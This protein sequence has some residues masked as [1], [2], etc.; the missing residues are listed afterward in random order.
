MGF[1]HS[2]AAGTNLVCNFIGCVSETDPLF[3]ST[4]THS[5]KVRQ[6][7]AVT[8]QNLNLSLSHPTSCHCSMQ[9]YDRCAVCCSMFFNVHILFS[10]VDLALIS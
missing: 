7:T 4:L 1:A 8:S 9:E 3:V 6:Q 2:G 10:M 5:R